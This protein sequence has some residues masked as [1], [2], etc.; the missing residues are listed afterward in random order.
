MP[1]PVKSPKPPILRKA[2]DLEERHSR[3]QSF[4]RQRRRFIKDKHL[5]QIVKVEVFDCPNCH[6]AYDGL[7]RLDLKRNR[8]VSDIIEAMNKNEDHIQLY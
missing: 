2:S 3:F 8:A 6:T 1:K 7:N 4:Q 5:Y